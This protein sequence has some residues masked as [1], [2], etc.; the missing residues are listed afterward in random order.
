MLIL[1]LQEY[2]RFKG[3]EYLKR[4]AGERDGKEIGSD[5]REENGMYHGRTI[6]I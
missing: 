6:R 4:R 2:T 5:N 3:K 1:A